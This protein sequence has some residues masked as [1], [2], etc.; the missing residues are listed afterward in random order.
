MEPVSALQSLAAV[1]AVIYGL[2]RVAEGGPGGG[3]RYSLLSRASRWARRSCG[4]RRG[5]PIR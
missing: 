2:K 1:L 3:L 5:W 4:G